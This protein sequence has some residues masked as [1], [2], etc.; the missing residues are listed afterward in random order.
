MHIRILKIM[1]AVCAG[2]MALFYV[3]QNF[4]NIHIAHGAVVYA[5]SGADQAIYPETFAFHTDSSALAWLAL[6]LI[7]ATELAAGVLMLKGAVD[8]WSN[9]NAGSATFQAAKRWV[10]IGAGLGVLVWFGFFGAIGAAFFQQ[11]QTA[12][13]EGSMNGAFQYFISCAVTLIFVHQ[14]DCEIA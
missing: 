14:P 12:A 3:L 9:R 13:G 8:M 10:E 2:L 7:C 11:W 6:M 1:F 5:M 4:A